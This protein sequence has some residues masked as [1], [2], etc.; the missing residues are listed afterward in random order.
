M[1]MIDFRKPPVLVIAMNPWLSGKLAKA[2]REAGVNVR[3]FWYFRNPPPWSRY[4]EYKRG[5]SDRQLAIWE[6]FARVSSANRGK[7][8]AERIRAIREAL[9]KRRPVIT[10]RA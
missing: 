7:P 8:V 10:T 4:R 5:A 1:T 3:K 2:A 9:S 6:E